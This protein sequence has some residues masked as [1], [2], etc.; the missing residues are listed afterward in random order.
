MNGV[1]GL[2]TVV[3]HRKMIQEKNAPRFVDNDKNM[4]LVHVALSL[5]SVT[6][7]KH[8]VGENA[9]QSRKHPHRFTRSFRSTSETI[10]AQIFTVRTIHFC[11]M[12]MF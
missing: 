11:C 3:T 5:L 6:L 8:V 2:K 7:C 12:L 4:K 9:N 10:I 1:C